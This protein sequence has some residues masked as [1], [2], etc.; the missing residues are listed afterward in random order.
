MNKELLTKLKHKK[1]IYER[2]PHGQEVQ[3]EYKDTIQE[4]KVK[5][6]KGKACL[7]LHLARGMRDNKKGFCKYIN[8]KRKMRGKCGTTAE[9][10]REHGG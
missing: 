8:N 5:I 2:K 10:S 3:E 7:I 6:R 4:C 9:C 1:E